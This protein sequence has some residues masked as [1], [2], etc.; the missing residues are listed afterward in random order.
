[1]SD[2][3]ME[4]NRQPEKADVVFFSPEMLRLADQHRREQTAPQRCRWDC[5]IF[6]APA[7]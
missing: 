3:R 4:Q 7:A 6:M 2:E 5:T 1:M